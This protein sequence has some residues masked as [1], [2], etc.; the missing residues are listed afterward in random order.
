MMALFGKQLTISGEGVAVFQNA[1]GGAPN[2]GRGTI[3]LDN[4]LKLIPGD[5]VSLYMTGIG[6]SVGDQPLATEARTAPPP[7]VFGM[8]WLTLCFLICMTACL[9]LRA[10]A[11][12]P[13]GAP[14]FRGV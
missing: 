4:I 10:V 5:I 1:A 9:L 6:L 11:S 8:S 13:I 14:G 12:K 7:I 2:A 3:N